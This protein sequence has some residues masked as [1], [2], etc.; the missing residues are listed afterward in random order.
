VRKKRIKGLPWVNPL[1]LE[2]SLSSLDIMNL[3]G[4]KN[5]GSSAT[6]TEVRRVGDP[7]YL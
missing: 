4:N 5:I 7:L 3:G 1:I 6:A 2:I